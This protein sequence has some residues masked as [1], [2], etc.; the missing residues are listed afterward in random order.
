MKLFIKIKNQI[1]IICKSLCLLWRSSKKCLLTV[2]FVNILAGLVMPIN[3]ILWRNFL[4]SVVDS[5]I[6]QVVVWLSLYGVLVV[7][8]TLLL[9]LCSYL[10]TMQIDYVNIYIS[11]ILLNKINELNL[12]DFDD[13]DTYNQ[14]SIV[15]GES[16]GRTSRIADNIMNIIKNLVTMLGTMGILISYNLSLV[17]VIIVSFLPLFLIN[18]NISQKLY[19]IFDER[20]ERI[21]FIEC[22]KNILIKYENIKEIKILKSNRYLKKIIMDIYNTHLKQD[23]KIR[24]LNLIKQTKA[25]IIQCFISYGIKIYIIIDFMQKGVDVGSINMYINSIDAV[26]QSIGEV[27]DTFAALYDDNLYLKTL[28]EFINR[29]PNK[30][31]HGK[32]RFDGNF[33][34]IC[35]KN[36]YFKYP[37]SNEYIL[38]GVN[39]LFEEK[40]SYMIVGINGAGK[41]TI[42]KLLSYLYAPTKGE[43]TIDDKDIKLFDPDLYR[44]QLSVVFQDFIRYP[45]DIETNIK[46]GDYK[47]AD[48]ERMKMAA[49]NI[50]I[51]DFINGLPQKYKTKLQSEWTDGVELSLG[52][53]QR[54]AIARADF[55]DKPIIIMDEPTASLDAHA[56]NKLFNDIKRITREKTLI[57]ISHRMMAAKDVDYIYVLKDNQ[58]IE[59]GSFRTLY[60]LNGEFKKMYEIQAEKYSNLN[61]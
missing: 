57:L 46:M 49:K 9:H 13:V 24:L 55:A 11:D 23:K 32:I 18:I 56:E 3:M 17:F 14:I 51:D 38:K 21:R 50:G 5:K 15:S 36:V 16:V 25:N 48:D 60:E 2:V 33:K 35:F 29:I 40:K 34:E 54:L 20:I 61:L 10:K 53:W 37:K 31:S 6:K 19:D 39:M 58:I 41:T 7:I 52:Q 26:Q 1:S 43:I 42:I 45:I 59:E 4:N 28:F 44:E 22:L 30:L 8:N 27:L 47:I 12:M